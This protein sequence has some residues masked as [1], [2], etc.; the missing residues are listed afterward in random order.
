[1]GRSIY[2]DDK[3]IDFVYI[4]AD[5]EYESV[6]KDIAAWHPKIRR[7]GIISGHDYSS[8][9]V[10]KAVNERFNLVNKYDGNVWCVT[11]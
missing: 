1:M 10:Y 4:D 9:G 8:S 2:I 6:R 5:H 11:V 7:G 3:S